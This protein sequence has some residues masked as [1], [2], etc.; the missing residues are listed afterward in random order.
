[1]AVGFMGLSLESGDLRPRK[2][3]SMVGPPGSSQWKIL[4]KLPQNAWLVNLWTDF[5]NGTLDNILLGL[6]WHLQNQQTGHW[7]VDAHRILSALDASNQLMCA[8]VQTPKSWSWHSNNAYSGTC[9]ERKL[10][11]L[12]TP[13][14]K[15]SHKKL[16]TSGAMNNAK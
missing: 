14:T 12:W 6:C 2:R 7:R 1:M 10:R 11:R 5:Q 8:V 15:R 13:L 16:Q 9:L 3:S 4:N